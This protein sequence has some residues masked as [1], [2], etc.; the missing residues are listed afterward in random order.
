MII[1]DLVIRLYEFEDY[2]KGYFELLNQ[3]TDS[4]KPDKETLKKFMTEICKSSEIWNIE[5]DNKII[6][7]GKLVFEPKLTHNLCYMAHIEEIVIDKE[8]RGKGLGKLLIKHLL[9][10]CKH[11]YKVILNC[12]ETNIRFYQQ[13]GFNKKDAQMSIYLD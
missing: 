10:K 1:E 6:G 13:C 4:P 8:F 7:T 2:D 9:D 3:L 5:Y 11:C 12:N